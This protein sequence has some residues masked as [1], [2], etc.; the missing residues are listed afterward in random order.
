MKVSPNVQSS[1]FGASLLSLAGAFVISHFDSSMQFARNAQFLDAFAY[2]ALL[3]LC[4]A[5]PL[6]FLVIFQCCLRRKEKDS[7][8]MSAGG[9]AL[10]AYAFFNIMLYLALCA[11]MAPFSVLCVTVCVI[12]GLSSLAA[13]IATIGTYFLPHCGDENC[14]WCN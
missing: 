9:G 5:L 11:Q 4:I 13:A 12:G 2:S 8:K 10:I 14:K 7:L 3:A 6:G 1:L